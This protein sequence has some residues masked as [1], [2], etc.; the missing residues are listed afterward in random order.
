MQCL[1]TKIIVHRDVLC[2][3]RKLHLDNNIYMSY[4]IG[5]LL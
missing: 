4:I 5:K 1:Y 2:L 3:N